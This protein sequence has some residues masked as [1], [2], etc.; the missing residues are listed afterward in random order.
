[1][2]R[3]LRSD[4]LRTKRLL[5]DFKNELSALESQEL[6]REYMKKINK[7]QKKIKMLSQQIGAKSSSLAYVHIYSDEDETKEKDEEENEMAQMIK[8]LQQKIDLL[9]DKLERIQKKLDKTNDNNKQESYENEQSNLRK[10]LLKKNRRL[11]QLKKKKQ[12]MKKKKKQQ[13]SELKKE[14]KITDQNN[15]IVKIKN[16]QKQINKLN[17][18]LQILKDQLSHQSNKKKKKDKNKIRIGKSDQSTNSEQ[19]FNVDASSDSNN[20]S[21]IQER[22]KKKRKKKIVY[23]RKTRNPND[24]SDEDNKYDFSS[25]SESEYVLY[26][27]ELEPMKI[28]T[29][30]TEEEDNSSTEMGTGSKNKKKRKKKKS[31]EQETGELNVSWEKSGKETIP[32]LFQNFEEKGFELVEY[33]PNS[34]YLKKNYAERLFKKFIKDDL[35]FTNL[36]IFFL[37]NTYDQWKDVRLK[38]IKMGR[39][40]WKIIDYVRHY[41]KKAYKESDLWLRISEFLR[42]INVDNTGNL[43]YRPGKFWFDKKRAI[44]SIDA[45]GKV[46][47][48]DWKKN[49]HIFV[50]KNNPQHFLLINHD[51]SE[52]IFIETED[53]YQRRVFLFLLLQYSLTK[54]KNI[55]IGNN[56]RCEEAEI[57]KINYNVKPPLRNVHSGDKKHLI[58]MDTINEGTIDG[59]KK[60]TDIIQEGWERGKMVFLCHTIINRI[61]PF[62]PSYFTVGKKSLSINL[63]QNKKVT[64]KYSKEVVVESKKENDS[65][66][67][68]TDITKP[69]KPKIIRISANSAPER[70]I[71][72][73]AIQYFITKYDEKGKNKK[74]RRRNTK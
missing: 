33:D 39:E 72:L 13:D 11:I 45:V 35:N 14:L 71:I 63:Y 41:F 66:F 44:I 52:H 8:G 16:Q 60:A 59:S 53:I 2:N 51:H 48:I 49:I 36:E 43:I 26:G 6:Q 25:T 68:V 70:E 38:E 10:K 3:T 20:E 29:S 34:E 9:T 40:I 23:K 21:P 47:E 19:V 42:P 18:D 58:T 64:M 7:I 17:Q 74:R 5:K 27:S 12:K 57:D 61:V 67:F 28:G 22:E 30:S 62:Y 56:P 31:Q 37:L 69:N 32:V 24:L 46:F 1:M 4:L 54:G 50:N 73:S 55:L 15:L 65:L